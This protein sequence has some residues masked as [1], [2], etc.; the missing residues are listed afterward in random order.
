MGNRTACPVA[1][2][3]L[4]VGVPRLGSWIK[5]VPSGLTMKK[6][7]ALGYPTP[8]GFQGAFLLKEFNAESR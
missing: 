2:E 6:S 4:G 1:D 3:V 7:A 5:P 8:I